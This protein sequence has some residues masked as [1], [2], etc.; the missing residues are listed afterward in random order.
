MSA[1]SPTKP[2]LVFDTEVYRD[3][4]LVSFLNVATGNIRHF[5]MFEGQPLDIPTLRAVLLRHRLVSFNG[6][7]F[8][9]PLITLALGGAGPERLKDV[10][11]KIIKNN[12]PYWRLGIDVLTVDH[13]DLIEVAP[14]I[15]SLKI[16]GG[17]LHCRRLQDLPIEPEASI[18]PEDRPRLREYCENDLKLT[19]DLYRKLLPQL[20]LRASMSET[21]GIDLRSK[22]DAQ[23]AEAVIKS[24]VG[25]RMGK[26]LLPPGD[27]SG[28]VFRYER[29]SFIVAQGRDLADTLGLIEQAVFT[30][31]GNGTVQM[32]SEIAE[33][34][35]TISESVYRMGIGGLH[36]SEKCAAHKAD[37][38]TVLRDVDVASYYP[39]IILNCG[40]R[41]AQMGEHFSAV[42]QGLVERR[43]AAKRAG[44][45]V[46]ADAL[47]I[48]INGSFGKFGSPY[49][50]LYSPKLLIQT[51]ITG[52]LSL[53]MLIET[54][55]GEGIP[56]VSANTDGIVIKCPKDKAP[57]MEFIVWEW[58][59]ATGFDTESTYYRAI[60]LRDVNNYI[61]I[62]TGTGVKLKGAYAPPSLQKN[63]TNE[64]CSAAVVKH[65]RDG[66]PI[67]ETIRGCR[68]VTKF[69]NVRQVNGGAMKGDQF[70]G[71]VVRWYY[72]GEPGT[73]NYKL[74]GYTV[75]R[76][77]G[78][79][80]LMDLPDELPQDVD[81]GWYIAEANSILNDIGATQG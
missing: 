52:Q 6:N 44:E 9:L 13:I 38:H 1:H 63:P 7:K 14:G 75:P 76:T 24:E 12:M 15:A 80:P 11:N 31:R 45:N 51:T 65:L 53:L 22:S 81:F 40:L 21:Y 28:K 68:D 20:E 2:V 37:E 67:E 70:L 19:L 59:T 46:T 5:E 32:P 79:K 78:A 26:N 49:S 39:R 55:E 54:L 72:A 71:K 74:N 3:Y 25:K 16:Y 29:P 30:I 23:I 57:L 64:I 42:Y 73:I 56:V 10:C 41:P 50:L 77:E 4:F 66:T 36:S 58:E 34:K 62:K 8:D 27:L 18:P 17:R 60:Y 33:L 35:I 47:K 43:L 61:A 48:T 69:V